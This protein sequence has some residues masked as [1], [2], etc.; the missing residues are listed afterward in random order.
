MPV[1]VPLFTEEVPN[2]QFSLQVYLCPHELQP[3]IAE[4][5]APLGWPVHFEAG[6]MSEGAT[7]CVPSNLEPAREEALMALLPPLRFDRQVLENRRHIGVQFPRPERKAPWDTLLV[8]DSV[9]AL[10]IGTAWLKMLGIPIGQRELGEANQGHRF[11][12]EPKA[13][14]ELPVLRWLMR[15]LGGTPLGVLEGITPAM[16]PLSVTLSSAKLGLLMAADT[17]RV[18]LHTDEPGLARPLVQQLETLG[19]GEIEV[20]GL[21][22]G[23]HACRPAFTASAEPALSQLNPELWSQLQDATRTW[24]AEQGVNNDG[25][26]LEPVVLEGARTQRHVTRD[27]NTVVLHLPLG[28]YKRNELM[29]YAGA[30][31]QRFNVFVR[32]PR[33]LA[34]QAELVAQDLS[35]AGFRTNLVQ[36]PSG[37]SGRGFFGLSGRAL[38]A[39]STLAGRLTEVVEARWSG[40]LAAA[41]PAG[42]PAPV[43]PTW[44]IEEGGPIAR[45]EERVTLVLPRLSQLTNGSPLELLRDCNVSIHPANARDG[46]RLRTR[47][48]QALPGMRVRLAPPNEDMDDG[49]I[50][51]GG[52]PE[53]ALTALA[54]LIQAGGHV[55]CVPRK[56]W[57]DS[58]MDVRI[59]LAASGAVV[60]APLVDPFPEH[61]GRTCSDKEGFVEVSACDV[62]IGAVVLPRRQG[63]LHPLAPDL[64]GFAAMSLDA[65]T[66]RVLSQLAEAVLAGEPCLLE[67]PTAATKTSGILFLAAL[68]GQPVLRINL[69]GQTDATE[70]M[71]Q[72][73]PLPGGG[74]AWSD[75]AAV[76]AVQHGLWLV[77]DELNLAPPQVMERLNSLLERPASLTLSERDM[78]VWGPGGQSI[79]PDFRIFGTMN[80]AEYAGRSALSAAGKDRWLHQLQVAAPDKDAVLAMLVQAVFGRQPQAGDWGP[81]MVGAWQPPPLV[82]LADPEVD[83]MELLDRVAALQ[84]SVW[85]ATRPDS[86]QGL[87]S[88]RR[89]PYVFTRRGLLALLQRVER[90]RSRG[91]PLDT[92]WQAGLRQAF[93]DRVAAQD[94]GALGLLMDAVGLGPHA[95]RT[96]ASTH[97]QPLSAQQEMEQM[98]KDLEEQ[99]A[100]PLRK[101]VGHVPF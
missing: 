48:L 39:E 28:R 79:H 11:V 100:T 87:G 95:W 18:R 1:A 51:Y 83:T 7:L 86:A 85:S 54:E 29:P 68:L 58:D 15:R 24:L 63:P 20:Q 98:L 3:A 46:E 30:N 75:G 43:L 82:P 45:A 97:E 34:S 6:Q 66:R 50:A 71:G 12:V 2:D 17:V 27:R 4:L 44:R 77:L 91:T 94:R 92:A 47:L 96:Q 74:F 8:A 16:Q 32:H 49:H 10:A 33:E 57:D 55:A 78:T 19:L 41:V 70:L 14:G 90:E 9:Q 25:W 80:P 73:Q 67:G 36:M 13:L 38:L 52:C 101:E 59:Y 5:L 22:A 35:T 76:R 42:S 93:V 89:E 69:S 53:P 64:A 21:P 60:S 62:R 81:A 88:D 40:L 72:F 23:P 26:P 37:E 99:A 31:P 84:V 56:E 65:G 61:W